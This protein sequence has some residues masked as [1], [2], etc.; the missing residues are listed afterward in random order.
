MPRYQTI[1]FDLDGTVID[2]A[3]GIVQ[4]IRYT[5]EHLG[6]PV[7]PMKELVHWVG[8]PLPQSFQERGGLPA[9]D[10]PRAMQIYRERYLDVGAY[11]SRV[12]DGMGELLRDLK[13]DGR[14]LALAT[15]KP[16]TPAVL[17]L[18][19]FSLI[20]FFDVIASAN[21]DET[22]GEKHEVI[23]FALSELEQLEFPTSSMVMVGDR[24]HDIHGSA[25]HGVDSIAVQWGYGT[26]A[27]WAEAHHT[28]ETPRQLRNLLGLA[29]PRV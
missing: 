14:H 17:M 9:A 13:N 1:L 10:V 27:E 22:R 2:S 23:A 15:S 4:S 25:H 19:H 29:A 8:P 11:D 5:L 28:V 3:P 21:D 18:E 6:H 12:F 20:R 26:S 7:P 24:I 16:Y